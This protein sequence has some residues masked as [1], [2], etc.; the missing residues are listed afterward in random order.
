M[1]SVQKKILTSTIVRIIRATVA[2]V[3]ARRVA[4][5]LL[6]SG[7]LRVLFLLLLVE[8]VLPVELDVLDLAV[9]VVAADASFIPSGCQYVP[10]GVVL[11]LAAESDAAAPSELLR[12]LDFSHQR[13]SEDDDDGNRR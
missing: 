5:A 11:S 10:T 8:F 7:L 9:V 1:G 6:R 12:R 13:R 4:E 3:A 2:D